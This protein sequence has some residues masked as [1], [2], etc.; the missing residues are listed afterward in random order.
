MLDKLAR[1]GTINILLV[2]F[3]ILEMAAFPYFTGQ[4]K[5][6]SGGTGMLDVSLFL[7]PEQIRQMVAAYGEAGRNI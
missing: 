1:R 3:L 6:A 5:A 7:T 2:L 4:L